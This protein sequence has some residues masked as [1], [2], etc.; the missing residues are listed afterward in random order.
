MDST[1]IRFRCVTCQAN[2]EVE[3]FWKQAAPSNPTANDR[4]RAIV[5]CPICGTKQEVPVKK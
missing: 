4:S 2:R 3:K 5:T 1:I